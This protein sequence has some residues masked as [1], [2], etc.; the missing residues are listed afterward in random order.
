[1]LG[2]I[3]AGPLRE[4]LAEADS[5]VDVPHEL[6][7]WK[8]GD[9]LLTVEGD[10]MTG[11]GI[12]W[13]DLVLLRPDVQLRRG[14]I[15]AVLYGEDYQTTLKR[16]FFDP[17][18]PTATLRASNPAYADIEVPASQLQVAGAYRGLVRPSV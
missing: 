17:G 4:A 7:D 15:A 1:M 12:F 16:V 6:L 13:G 8:P 18:K 3:P 11:D 2:S 9:F 14:E 10:S 5:F